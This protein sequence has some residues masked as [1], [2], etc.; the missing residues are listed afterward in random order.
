MQRA[1]VGPR[2]ANADRRV[3]RTR[4]DKRSSAS[5]GSRVICE[6]PGGDLMAAVSCHA[7]TWD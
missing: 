3:D 7:T 2:T 6:S 4:N 1:N 5:A